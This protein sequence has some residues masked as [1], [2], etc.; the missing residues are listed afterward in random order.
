MREKVPIELQNLLRPPPPPPAGLHT[1]VGAPWDFPPQVYCVP[2]ART[3]I[4]CIDYRIGNA[5]S[6]LRIYSHCHLHLSPR[7]LC[8]IVWNFCRTLAS[9]TEVW[10]AKSTLFLLPSPVARLV[11]VTGSAS[12]AHMQV[13]NP[14]YESMVQSIAVD[15]PPPQ[16]FSLYVILKMTDSRTLT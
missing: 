3:I 15:F 5:H 10:R 2:R 12:I 8:H 1:E 6:I 13:S 14:G 7:C 4:D 16:N 9:S 11:S